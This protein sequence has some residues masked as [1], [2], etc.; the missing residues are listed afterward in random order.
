MDKVCIWLG[1]GFFT[2]KKSHL[3]PSSIANKEHMVNAI[4]QKI[5]VEHKA[6]LCAIRV[7]LVLLF[8]TTHGEILF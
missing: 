3:F 4:Q 5:P 8:E 2:L 1:I 6:L 7:H